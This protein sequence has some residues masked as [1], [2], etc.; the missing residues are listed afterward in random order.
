M[1]AWKLSTIILASVL[2]G[3]LVAQF[4]GVGL[5]LAQS[6]ATTKVQLDTSNCTYGS[7]PDYKVPRGAVV[8][9]IGETRFGTPIYSYNVCK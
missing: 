9:S 5:V 2:A 1:N 6:G 8:F 7:G 4:A 3:F